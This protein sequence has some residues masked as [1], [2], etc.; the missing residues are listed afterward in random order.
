MLEV[1]DFFEFEGVVFERTALTVSLKSL[2]PFSIK[3]TRDLGRLS[4]ERRRNQLR[5]I[6]EDFKRK[7]NRPN[8]VL[9]IPDR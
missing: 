9:K 6:T 8:D 2:S 7:I 5:N 4:T 3:G 1:L